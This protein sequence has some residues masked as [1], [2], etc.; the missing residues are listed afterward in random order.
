MDFYSNF[1]RFSHD[2]HIILNSEPI[3]KKI[4]SFYGLSAHS[5]GLSVGEIEVPSQVGEKR[6]YLARVSDFVSWDMACGS[7]TDSKSL[8][9]ATIEHTVI[10][11]TG[12]PAH[13]E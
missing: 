6:R 5:A 10:G 9:V 7:L 2:L 8:T 4:P 1:Y 3:Y 12:R 11:M 13:L